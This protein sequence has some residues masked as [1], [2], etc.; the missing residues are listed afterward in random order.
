MRRA[1][2]SILTLALLIP[3]CSTLHP[4][5]ETGLANQA[6]ILTS[7]DH[8]YEKVDCAGCAQCETMKATVHVAASAGDGYDAIHAN[9]K[10]H[11]AYLDAIDKAVPSPL[12]ACGCEV[13]A[14]LCV[15]AQH[16]LEVAR[17]NLSIRGTLDRRPWY[18][19]LLGF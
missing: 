11:R 9:E 15:N 13:D 6:A 10:Q 17:E 4:V 14:A 18:E 12:P 8:R 19:R 7:Y 1:I 2:L 16:A 3:A 5:E